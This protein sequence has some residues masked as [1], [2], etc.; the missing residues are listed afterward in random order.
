MENCEKKTSSTVSINYWNKIIY[1]LI[2]EKFAFHYSIYVVVIKSINHLLITYN[3]KNNY[4]KGTS[5]HI[6]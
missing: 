1:M 5:L 4:H 2:D 6:N 3:K